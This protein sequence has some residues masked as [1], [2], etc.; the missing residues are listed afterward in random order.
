[1]ICASSQDPDPQRVEDLMERLLKYLE[2]HFCPTG[3]YWSGQAHDLTKIG[4]G[5]AECA[6]A[7]MYM[8]FERWLPVIELVT[9]FIY[10][11]NG[12]CVDEFNKV[13]QLRP[14]NLKGSSIL[15]WS[16]TFLACRLLESTCSLSNSF[17]RFF[18]LPTFGS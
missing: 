1:M 17:Y 13:N 18:I 11:Q 6:L 15:L 16:L 9:Q 5:R 3:V 8:I 12:P 10:I 14:S 7:I 4:A 2:S